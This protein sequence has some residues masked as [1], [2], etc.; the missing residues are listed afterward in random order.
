MIKC[1]KYLVSG[2]ILTCC[3]AGFISRGSAVTLVS[4]SNGL[5]G[6][7]LFVILDV[8][9]DYWFAPAW[10]NI[11]NGVDYYRDLEFEP[12]LT[13]VGIIEPFNWPEGVGQ[14]GGIIF[15]GALTTPDMDALFGSVDSLT[16]GWN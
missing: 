13:G 12:G 11:Q 9:G 10:T 2:L 7:P 3:L 14:A 6:Y 5:S 4:K 1:G 16:F 15:W 8:Y